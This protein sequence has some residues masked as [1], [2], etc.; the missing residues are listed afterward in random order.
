MWAGSSSGP[1]G[2][3]LR[4][5]RIDLERTMR[6]HRRLYATAICSF[7]GA[8]AVPLRSWAQTAEASTQLTA[9]PSDHEA[10]DAAVVIPPRLLHAPELTFPARA[11]EAGLSAGVVQVRVT[12]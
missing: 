5:R 9:V 2:A 11:Q 3:P 4:A 1:T 12:V 10:S 7:L 8:S 6:A